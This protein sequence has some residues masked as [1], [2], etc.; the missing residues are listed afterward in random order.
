MKPFYVGTAL[1][2]FYRVHMYCSTGNCLVYLA[3]MTVILM[4][5]LA[6]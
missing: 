5:V 1:C 4:Q 6:G 3:L 2:F